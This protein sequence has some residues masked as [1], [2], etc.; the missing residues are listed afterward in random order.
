V[1]GYPAQMTTPPDP[2]LLATASAELIS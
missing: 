1:V 2:L